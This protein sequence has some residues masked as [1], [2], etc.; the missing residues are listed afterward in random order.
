MRIA[1]GQFDSTVGDL[2]ANAAAIRSLAAEATADGADLLVLPEMC[3]LGYPPRDLLLR[4]EVVPACE[5]M[6]R[7][8]ATELPL[9]TLVGSPREV[10]HGS[11][12]IA[13]AVAL[14]R[15]GRVEAW[16]D[17][18]LLPTYDVFDENRWF[19][20]GDQPLVFELAGRRV[21]VLVCEDLWRAEDVGVDR[22]YQRD[23]VTMAIEA[24]CNLLVSPSA[25]PFIVGKHARHQALLERVART[26]SIP[27]VMVN[28]VGANDDLVFDGGSAVFDAAG[29][30]LASLPRFEPACD[31]VDLASP[32]AATRSTELEPVEERYLA[33]TAGIEGYCRKTSQPGVLLGLSGG[34]DSALTA[35]LAVAALG[36]QQVQGVI[37]PSRYSSEGSRV[38]ARETVRRLRMPVAPEISIDSLHQAVDGDLG[39]VLA[40]GSL[41]GIA[42]ENVQ[43]R[44]RGLLLMGLSNAEGRMLLATSNKSELAVGYST[45]YGDMCGGLMPLGDVYKTD[46]FALARWMNLHHERLG[47]VEQPIPPSSIDKPPSAELRPD[48]CDSDS[49]PPYEQLDAI[50]RLR[51]DEERSLEFIAQ[52]LGV[53]ATL[54]EEVES[55]IAR[56][57]FKRY[58]STVIP[59][60]A[61]RSFGPGRSLPL[62]ARWRSD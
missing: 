44:L 14:C 46:A 30:C 31:V 9:P 10:A 35:A 8:L 13:N 4:E 38:D 5:A 1:L 51:I 61:P 59:K 43:A 24:G 17:K 53:D 7:Q 25:S 41:A 20:S 39:P 42:D 3:L 45:L 52:T 22:P 6:V 12:P 47:F 55:L 34:L 33:I 26:S 23:P 54:L 40:A 58:Q 28:Q 2:P 50:L 36:P 62:A 11:R 16:H 15:G 21:G 48:Q 37:L 27:I 56:S 19:Q 57:E 32:V 18:I 60:L 49:L 29:T